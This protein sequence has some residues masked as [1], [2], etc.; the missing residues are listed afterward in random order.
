MDIITVVE[1]HWHNIESAF[2]RLESREGF[3][4][5]SVQRQMA[6]AVAEWLS[7]GESA[8][9]EAPTGVGKSLA[10]LIPAI[11]FCLHSEPKKRIV[12]ATY[13]NVLAQQYWYKDLPLALSLFPDSKLSVALAMGRTRYA[14]HERIRRGEVRQARPELVRM[15]H[16]WLG[17]AEEGTEAELNAFFERKGVPDRF[18][19]GLWEQI[20]V[21]SVCRARVC[22]YYPLCF[23]YTNRQQVA[24][25][26]LVVTN[27]AVVLTDALLKQATDDSASLLDTYDYLILDEAHDFVEATRSA[28][29]S[30]LSQETLDELI[31]IASQMSNQISYATEGELPPYGFLMEVQ[32]HAQAFA[33]RC[34]ALLKPSLFPNLPSE[35]L[36]THT[37]PIELLQ[38]P[39]L[40]QGAR[41]DLHPLTVDIVN[42]LRT[43]IQTLLREIRHSYEVHR[44]Q[45]SKNQQQAVMEALS[46]YETWFRT[47]S[48]QLAR[49]AE[50]EEG[51]CWIEPEENLFW[52]GSE[53]S[54]RRGFKEGWRA[55]WQPLD[56]SEW[57]R[58]HLFD[59]CPTLMM[60]ATL[61]VDG[62]FDFFLQQVGLETP[63][64]LLLPLVFD[65]ARQCALYLP[66][67]GTIPSPPASIRATGAEEYYDLVA[68]ELVK[69]L[70]ATEG[71]A[72]V[73]FASRTEMEAVRARIP[74]L[75][76]IPI[77][78]QGE[79]SN[80]ELSRRFREQTHSV[81]FGLRSFWTG[82]DAPGET[83]VNL[84]IV[85]IPFEVPTTPVQRA[86]QAKLIWDGKD[87]FQE[88]SLPMVKQ[89]IRQGFGR[90]IR[91]A[92]DRGVVCLL[93]PRFQTRAYG[94]QI[95]RNL[96]AGIRQFS[97]IEEAVAFLNLDAVPS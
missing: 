10:V 67:K 9:V 37:M 20:A 14:C 12:I 84:V 66:P 57:L 87:P 38:L 92:D 59:N 21:P 76:N 8:V 93:D 65:Y 82:F 53:P 86:R 19:R 48:Q 22:P 81:L 88:W 41:P 70:M 45:L 17:V 69:V 60:S 2:Q 42:R 96:P 61:A 83:L 25:A 58:T 63:R 72:L 16:E 52:E 62:S 11:A 50:P 46:Q 44:S 31:R 34:A 51:V 43:E 64:R 35:G 91:R 18:L 24:R 94:R 40:S 30:T 33:Q 3:E 36:I 28:L 75:P 56:V 26:Q 71:R 55:C 85:R 47:F 90:L 23:Y 68:E 89:Q 29:Q 15:L 77:Y 32:G 54:Q 79:L 13:T 27:H 80:A 5:R 49:L 4:L 97:A 95:I 73:L 1:N 6:Q 7:R 78:M 39:E 74:T